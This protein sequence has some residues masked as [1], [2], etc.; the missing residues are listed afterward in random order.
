MLSITPFRGDGKY[1]TELANDDYYTKGGEPRGIWGG[2]AAEFFDLAR[3][4]VGKRQLRSLLQGFDPHVAIKDRTTAA[5]LVQ[6]AGNRRRQTGYDC[7]FNAPKSVSV[8]WAAA[9]REA[10]QVI[11]T[12]HREAVRV[13]M[14]LLE[15]YGAFTRRGKRGT[16][17]E[18]ARLVYAMFEHATSRAEEPHLHTH[19]LVP[20]LGVRMDGTTGTLYSEVLRDEHGHKATYNPLMR[21]QKAIGAA[22]RSHL[23]HLL[24]HRLGLVIAAADDGFSFELRDIP[25]DACD[26]YSTRRRQIEDHL[27]ELGYQSPEAA[28][29]ANKA[30]RVPKSAISRPKLFQKWKRK[31]ESFGLDEEFIKGICYQAHAYDQAKTI[32]KAIHK[33][34]DE[35]ANKQAS[36]RVSELFEEVAKRTAEYGCGADH[37]K[38]RID[39]EVF[40]GSLV[41]LTWQRNE[42]LLSTQD[43]LRFEHRFI[44]SLQALTERLGHTV[45]DSTVDKVLAKRARRSEFDLTDEQL[46]ALRYLVSGTV[47]GQQI[48]SLRISIGDAGTGKTTLLKTA[49]E[50]WNLAGYR[51]YGASLSGVATEKLRNETGIEAYTLAKWEFERAKNHLFEFLVQEGRD[52]V[53]SIRGLPKDT[54]ST[55]P[56]LT[57]RSVLVVDETV[58]ADSKLLYGLQRAAER[59]GSLVVWAGD[60]K[61]LQAI[62]HG[63]AFIQA[64]RQVPPVRLTENFRQKDPADKEVARLQAEGNSAEALRN[65][66]E[67]GKVFVGN[68]VDDTHAMLT[69]MWERAGGPQNPRGHQV[70]CVTNLQRQR[71][72]TELQRKRWSTLGRFLAP[73]IVNHEGQK[74][75]LGDRLHFRESLR[76]T[77][78]P[79]TMTEKLTTGV[80][81]KLAHTYGGHVKPK[82]EEVRNGS[83]GTLVGFNP[84]THVMQVKM[85]DGRLL[86]VP[87]RIKDPASKVPDVFN[88]KR[89]AKISL[90]YAITTHSSQAA[91]FSHTYLV[92]YGGTRNR[93][94]AYV[95]LTRGEHST[96]LFTTFQYAGSELDSI[97][98]RGR[99]QRFD[100]AT[101]EQLHAHNRPDSFQPRGITPLEESILVKQMQRSQKK[102]FGLEHVL[103]QPTDIEQPLHLGDPGR[104]F[105]LEP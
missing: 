88:F 63:G 45:P 51:V 41:S 38:V 10:H 97:A 78:P 79:V 56:R 66:A 5:K 18:P 93:E 77:Q 16:E 101:L 24:H 72:N 96:E 3:R 89:P 83:M 40:E 11:E 6:N 32:D 71:L 70:I 49:R 61:Q 44:K 68:S 102:T 57:N 33:A 14:K 58:M 25:K 65:M 1:F 12:C 17:I 29:I 95:Q 52:A 15:E 91:S 2:T 35:L 8:A 82:R 84:L 100:E 54:R 92:G 43:N 75:Y 26:F 105:G 20:N 7:C 13:A 69:T 28:E 36:F 21:Q 19:V 73:F 55:F 90:G 39:K 4:K 47:D 67:R 81:K 99:V 27:A 34:A 59:A 37:I 80:Q 86:N 31:L 104:R 74:L 9:D 48:G 87:Y 85:D 94:Q 64:M 30:T 23:A 50:A 22:Y 53:R 42:R 103:Y 62:S 76:F 98:F 46:T 60:D